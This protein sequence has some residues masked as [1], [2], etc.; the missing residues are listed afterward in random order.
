MGMKLGGEITGDGEGTEEERK[1]IGIRPT[2]GLLQ[3]FSR[4]CPMG[5]CRLPRDRLTVMNVRDDKL[6]IR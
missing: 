5:T 2:R 1:G 4:G 6:E 3:L